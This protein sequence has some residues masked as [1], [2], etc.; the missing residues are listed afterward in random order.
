MHLERF[1][2]FTNKTLYVTRFSKK[3]LSPAGSKR[4][5]RSAE[6]WVIAESL[7]FE[8]HCVRKIWVYGRGFIKMGQKFG[9]HH[10]N[11][12]V[13][14]TN[15]FDCGIRLLHPSYRSCHLALTWHE[16]FNPFL[17]RLVY[18]TCLYHFMAFFSWVLWF[19]NGFF[20]LHGVFFQRWLVFL[21]FRIGG[22]AEVRQD[23]LV[24][25]QRCGLEGHHSDDLRCL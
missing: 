15:E 13:G 25:A 19:P 9:L 10:K 20:D 14:C 7:D 3:K 24:L 4:P 11:E 22:E 16:F 5:I 18:P 12:Y 2:L 1:L 6:G 21:F 8:L 23:G 17:N